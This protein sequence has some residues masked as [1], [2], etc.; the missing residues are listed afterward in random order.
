MYLLLFLFLLLFSNCSLAATYT[1]SVDDAMTE[2]NVTS[3]TQ[4]I[5]H[6]FTANGSSNYRVDWTC[7]VRT[8]KAE[9]ACN[10]QVKFDDTTIYNDFSFQS[11]PDVVSNWAAEDGFFILQTPSSGSHDIDIDFSSSV[12]GETACIKNVRIIVTDIGT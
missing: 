9:V 11:I 6:T 3:M 12:T 7:Q 5:K 2:T 4:K 1:F 8:I 10:V